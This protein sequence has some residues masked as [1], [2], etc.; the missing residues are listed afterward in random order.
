MNDLK[1]LAQ[2]RKYLD[3]AGHCI[4]DN[5]RQ[6]AVD[7]LQDVKRAVKTLQGICRLPAECGVF[8]EIWQ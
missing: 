8:D 3:D 1:I 4:K 6:G 2:I 5:D 7:K